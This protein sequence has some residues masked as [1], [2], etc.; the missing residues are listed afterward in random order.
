MKRSR[1]LHRLEWS[2]AASR[3]LNIVKSA[4]ECLH[5][6]HFTIYRTIFG[7]SIE[8]EAAATLSTITVAAT[9]SQMLDSRE[10]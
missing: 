2:T 8:A 3:H 7:F 5:V 1:T 9:I 6:E 4:N 10:Q